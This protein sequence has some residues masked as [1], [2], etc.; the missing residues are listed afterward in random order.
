MKRA[1]ACARK[2]RTNLGRV[3]R[4]VERQGDF[5]S[6][7]RIL[8]VCKRIHAQRVDDKDKIYSVHEPE[9]KCIAKGKA[10]M[11]YEFVQKVSVAVTKRFFRFLSGSRRERVNPARG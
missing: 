11:K 4:E 3:I 10:G 2:L 6:L 9:V 7:S 5:P 1:K 8:T